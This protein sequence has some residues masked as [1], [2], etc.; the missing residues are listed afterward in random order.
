MMRSDADREF[1]K[2]ILESRKNLRDRFNFEAA[3][4]SF[5]PFCPPTIPWAHYALSIKE[6]PTG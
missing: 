5:C 1:L 4:Y 3:D 6:L 2:D